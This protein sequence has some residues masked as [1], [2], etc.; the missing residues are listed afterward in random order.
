MSGAS[1]H[2]QVFFFSVMT[3]VI[4]VF[5]MGLL[6]D[7]SLF[8]ACDGADRLVADRKRSGQVDDAFHSPSQRIRHAVSQYGS[9]SPPAFS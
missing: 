5:Y 4:S 9:M 6:V 2:L 1:L 7:T 8:D 3:L